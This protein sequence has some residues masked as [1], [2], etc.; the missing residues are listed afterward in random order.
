[1]AAI[2]SDKYS[3]LWC[4]ALWPGRTHDSRVFR[5][6]EIYWMFSRGDI[7]GRVVRDRAYRALRDSPQR[8][9]ALTAT[10]GCFRNAATRMNGPEFGA[11]SGDEEDSESDWDSEIEDDDPPRML[12]HA[13]IRNC[14]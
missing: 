9:S 2:V 7:S 1:M 5:E 13:A 10:A 4:S 6:F 14:S 11:S 8:S 12:A 3:F